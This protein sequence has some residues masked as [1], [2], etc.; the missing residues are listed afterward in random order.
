MFFLKT[1]TSVDGRLVWR[2]GKFPKW[3]LDYLSTVD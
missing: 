2:R 3:F 1:E